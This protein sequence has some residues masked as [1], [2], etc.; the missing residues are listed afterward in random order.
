MAIL[1]SNDIALAKLEGRAPHISTYR[2]V[3]SQ[4]ASAFAWVD[5]SMAA[6]SPPAQY[7]ASSPLEAAV[8]EAKRGMYHGASNDADTFLTD[9]MLVSPTAGLCGVYYL[10]DYVLY[11]PFI[12]LD[13]LDT[14]VMDNTLT[15]PRFEDGE[16]VYPMLVTQAPTA[17]GEVLTFEYVDQD[18]NTKTSQSVKCDTT[19]VPIASVPNVRAAVASNAGPFAPLASGSRGVRQINSVTVTVGGGGLVAIVLV[20]PIARVVLYEANTPTEVCYIEQRADLPP[21]HDDAHLQLVVRTPSAVGAS[22]ILV[23]CP[24]F[25]YT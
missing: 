15:L 20:K 9:L 2:K 25:I 5:L 17:G 13:D 12:A 22:G 3:N 1:G 11:Y 21:I 4:A 18:G 7:Y 16:G 23:A 8:L 19:T 14:Q 6:G 24:S 10:L